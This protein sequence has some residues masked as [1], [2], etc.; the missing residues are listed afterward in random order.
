MLVQ[1]CLEDC[2][3]V[4]EGLALINR[5]RKAPA[6]DMLIWDKGGNPY[7]RF[8]SVCGLFPTYM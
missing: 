6:K 7:E 1:S 3:S 5:T 4:S 8:F 2:K